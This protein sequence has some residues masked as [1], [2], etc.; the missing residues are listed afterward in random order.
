MGWFLYFL[1][2]CA[3]AAFEAFVLLVDQ[4]LETDASEFSLLL[5][6]EIKDGRAQPIGRQLLHLGILWNF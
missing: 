2:E 4:V 5:L 6:E 3:I 1:L